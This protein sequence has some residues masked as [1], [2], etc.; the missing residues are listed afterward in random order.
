MKRL[1][2]VCVLALFVA[3]SGCAGQSVDRIDIHDPVISGESRRFVA[4]AEDAVS[5]AKSGVD[6]YR[7]QLRETRERRET[8]LSSKAWA[9]IQQGVVSSYEALLDAR[10]KLAELKLARAQAELDLA[11]EKLRAV[12]AE[13]AVRHDMETYDLE[14][15]RQQV[16][17]RLEELRKINRQIGEHLLVVD[18]A[19]RAWWKNYRGL[20]ANQKHPN[21]FFTTQ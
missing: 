20:L 6:E 4:D 18:E 2:F 8:M 12:Y 17:G 11:R 1:F 10:V 16:D 14:P 13:T 19:S 21:M 9:E 7:R 5:I 3:T 15:I